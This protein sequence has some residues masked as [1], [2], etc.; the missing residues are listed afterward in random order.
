MA[1]VEIQALSYKNSSCSIFIFFKRN[2]QNFNVTW[3]KIN[4]SSNLLISYP[5]ITQTQ[6]KHMLSTS[7]KFRANSHVK[8]ISSKTRENSRLKT[9]YLKE[10]QQSNYSSFPSCE[11]IFKFFLF[12]QLLKTR[13][14]TKA[15]LKQIKFKANYTHSF[16][17]VF[18]FHIFF[19]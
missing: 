7:F 14:E 3:N 11:I 2:F 18:I 9:R 8:S 6:I 5:S 4:S 19:N 12:I 17:L 1:L 16:C 13:Q 15:H 10:L